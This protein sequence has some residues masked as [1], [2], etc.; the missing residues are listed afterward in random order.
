[1][2]PTVRQGQALVQLVHLGPSP[3]MV[4]PHHARRV[5]L[6]NMLLPLLS[7]ASNVLLVPTQMPRRRHL[8]AL[9]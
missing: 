6:V 3:L 7:H 2:A 9:V 1:M 8:S 5:A 4:D